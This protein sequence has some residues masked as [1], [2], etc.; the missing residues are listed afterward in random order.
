MGETM[1]V[2]NG[3]DQTSSLKRTSST[4]RGSSL[5][6]FIL[7]SKK[8]KTMTSRKKNERRWKMRLLDSTKRE[9]SRRL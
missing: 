4:M 1:L 6:G 5:E 7:T 9:D 8:R 3:L 2:R